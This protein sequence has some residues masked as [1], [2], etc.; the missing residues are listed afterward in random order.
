M[1]GPGEHGAIVRSD[2]GGALTRINRGAGFARIAM[3]AWGANGEP[4]MRRARDR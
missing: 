1:D 4:G 2:R 3:S